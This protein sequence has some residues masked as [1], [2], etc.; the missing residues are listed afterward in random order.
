VGGIYKCKKGKKRTKKYTSRKQQ[1]VQDAQNKVCIYQFTS[2]RPSNFPYSWIH[3]SSFLR[4]WLR[5]AKTAVRKS[6]KMKKLYNQKKVSPTSK[7]DSKERYKI[8]Q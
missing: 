5:Y 4:G 7:L 2:L 8:V 6:Q 1:N 3:S